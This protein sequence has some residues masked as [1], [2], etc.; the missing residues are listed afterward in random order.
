MI[1]A[2]FCDTVWDKILSR[3]LE[4]PDLQALCLELQDI[5]GVDNVLALFLWVADEAGF[6]PTKPQIE[7]LMAE[8]KAWRKSVVQELRDIRRWLKPRVDEAAKG[9]LREAVKALELE[10][11][12]IELSTLVGHFAQFPEASGSI[13]TNQAA[14]AYLELLNVDGKRVAAFCGF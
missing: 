3:Y 2:D 14:R 4:A 1:R 10:A 5:Y 8:T 7:F 13:E 9:N 12:R 11:E 6:S